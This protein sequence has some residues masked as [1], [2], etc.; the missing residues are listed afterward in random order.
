MSQ[1]QDTFISQ[2]DTALRTLFNVGDVMRSNPAG[3][4]HSQLDEA[5][6]RVAAGLMRVNHV[7]EV[8]AQALYAGQGLVARSAQVKQF[9]IKAG[10]E[11]HDHLLWCAQRLKELNARPSVLNPLWYAGAFALGTVAGL[12]GDRTSLAFVR[13]TEAQVE[14]HLHRHSQELPPNDARSLAIVAQMKAD[15]ATHAEQATKLGA[16]KLPKPVQLTMK[17]SAKMMTLTAYYF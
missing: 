14:A 10:I 15:E 16:P 12:M 4:L 13:E 5:Q 3:V 9:N 8:C 17:A 1:T 7:G 2:A 6:R 11:E